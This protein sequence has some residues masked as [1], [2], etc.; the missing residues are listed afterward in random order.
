[1]STVMG[2]ETPPDVQHKMPKTE[3]ADGGTTKESYGSGLIK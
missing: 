3:G 2:P 1:M